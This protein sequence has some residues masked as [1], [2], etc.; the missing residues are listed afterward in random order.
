VEKD[1]DKLKITTKKI[2]K[3]A[4]ECFAHMGKKT[5]SA[6]L[7]EAHK[8]FDLM[9]KLYDKYVPLIGI[10]KFKPADDLYNGWD[11]IF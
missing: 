7:S 3:L 4:D 1:I 9:I 5:P 2:T 10:D 8:A 11:K 6:S